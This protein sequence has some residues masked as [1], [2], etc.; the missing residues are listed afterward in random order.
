MLRSKDRDGFISYH[1]ALPCLRALFTAGHT[2]RHEGSARRDLQES[3][4]VSGGGFDAGY[5]EV[6]A[7]ILATMDVR[8]KEQLAERI[9]ACTPGKVSFEH[10]VGHFP[11]RY[12][13][14]EN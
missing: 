12:M 6:G 3:L 13:A 5:L 2:C 14:T 4:S 9:D 1:A 11:T 7:R 8:E 10:L